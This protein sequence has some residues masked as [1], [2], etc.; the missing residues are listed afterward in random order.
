MKTDPRFSDGSVVSI[1][2][3]EHTWTK[4]ERHPDGDEVVLALDGNATIVVQNVAGDIRRVELEQGQ[5]FVIS[6][7]EWHWLETTGATRLLFITPHPARTEEQPL[8]PDGWDPAP[9]THD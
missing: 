2:D 6:R 8:S 7:G 4:R 5:W 1:F 3:Y 9:R